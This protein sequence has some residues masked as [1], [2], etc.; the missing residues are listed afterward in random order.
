MRLAVVLP[1]P[2]EART[3]ADSVA[4]TRRGRGAGD[5]IA[6][7]GDVPA[8]EDRSGDGSRG[9]ARAAGAR[10]VSTPIRDC[11]AARPAARGG[12]PDDP[13]GVGRR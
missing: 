7:P 6:E 9:F 13:A 11:V 10:V 3:G 2:N 4:G 12:G 5:G 8:A 1:C